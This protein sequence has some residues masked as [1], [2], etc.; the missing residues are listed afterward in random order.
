MGMQSRKRAF[1]GAEGVTLPEG[2]SRA[3]DMSEPTRHPT[4]CSTMARRTGTTQQPG[5]PTIF[6]GES[7]PRDPV[8]HPTATGLH[9]VAIDQ[10]PTAERPKARGTVAEADEIEGVGGP[11]SSD[12]AGERM[13]RG[14]GRAKAA[15]VETNLERE[16]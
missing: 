12:D 1:L 13:A 14:P 15:R 11:S 6:C 3:G 10:Q 4:G 16:P 9:V 7:G 2:N 5:I 8:N